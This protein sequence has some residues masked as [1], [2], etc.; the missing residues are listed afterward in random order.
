MHT[1]VPLS[2]PTVMP[3]LYGNPRVSKIIRWWRCGVSA[4]ELLVA[5][6]MLSVSHLQLVQPSRGLPDQCAVELPALQLR[7]TASR[8]EL[9]SNATHQS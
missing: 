5:E 4:L 6:S 8:A 9:H 7:R 3:S 1:Y 2:G